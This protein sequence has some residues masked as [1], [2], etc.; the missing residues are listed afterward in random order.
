MIPHLTNQ[1]QET[2]DISQASRP[3]GQ[4]DALATIFRVLK[5]I[6]A[7][8]Y[9]VKRSLAELDAI[10]LRMKVNEI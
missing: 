2:P 10:K 8:E 1:S 7:M 6:E 4:A 3:I 5:D 9:Q